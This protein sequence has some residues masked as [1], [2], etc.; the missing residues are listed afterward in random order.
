MQLQKEKHVDK[1]MPSSDSGEL[2]DLAL[3][4]IVDTQMT[5][6]RVSNLKYESVRIDSQAVVFIR[7]NPGKKETTDRSGS[8]AFSFEQ[9]SDYCRNFRYFICNAEVAT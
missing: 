4:E 8:H 1:P 7:A 9:W 6:D 2:N 5:N 3:E